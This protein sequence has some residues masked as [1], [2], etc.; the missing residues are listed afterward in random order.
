MKAFFRAFSVGLCVLM[1]CTGIS[2]FASTAVSENGHFNTD[3]DGKERYYVGD[4]YLKDGVYKIGDYEYVFASDGECLGAYDGYKNHGTLGLM[5]NERF[6]A[7]LAERTVHI[8]QSNNVGDENGVFN[9]GGTVNEVPKTVMDASAKLYPQLSGNYVMYSLSGATYSL[10]PKGGNAQNGNLAVFYGYPS[11]HTYCDS[12]GIYNTLGSEN[13]AIIDVEIK[14]EG[15]FAFSGKRAL[16][17]VTDRANESGESANISITLLQMDR[18]GMVYAKGV[19]DG[20]VALLNT[21]EFTRLSVAFHINENTFDV[22]LNGVLIRSG[23]ALYDETVEGNDAFRLEE[24]RICNA[25]NNDKAGY[26]ID[27]FSVYSGDKPVCLNAD[28]TLK[29]GYVQEGSYLRYY[30]NG[31][32]FT[33]KKK[34]SGTFFGKTLE[35]ESVTFSSENGGAMIGCKLKVTNGGITV[36]D[37]FAKNNTFVA[38]STAMTGKKQLGWSLTANGNSSFVENG[39]SIHL[40]YDTEASALGVEF[41]MLSGASV[42]LDGKENALR[43]YGKISKADLENLKSLGL[44]VEIHIVTAPTSTFEKAHGYIEY[45]HLLAASDGEEKPVDTVIKNGK[46]FKETDGYFYYSTVIGGISD[47]TKEYS[48]VTYLKITIENGSTVDVYGDYSEENNSRSVYDVAF[49]AYNDRS[50]EKISGKATKLVNYNGVRTYS[51]YSRSERKSLENIVNKVVS[52]VSEGTNAKASGDFYE[53]PYKISVEKGENGYTVKLT[54]Y[55]WSKNKP[56]A[57]TVNGESISLEACTLDKDSFSFGYEGDKVYL[58]DFEEITDSAY[59]G[60]KSV[61]ISSSTDSEQFSGVKALPTTIGGISVVSPDG[62]G[63]NA[64]LWEYTKY[65]IDLTATASLQ[66]YKKGEKYD[67]SGVKA[68]SFRVYVPNGSENSTFYIIADSATESNADAYYSYAVKLENSGW[69]NIF[70]NLSAASQNGTPAGWD[71]IDE[72][73][74]TSSGWSQSNSTSTRLLFYEIAAYDEKQSDR[75]YNTAGKISGSYNVALF[76]IGGYAGAVEGRIIPIN[77]L[78]RDV[79]V[80]KDTDGVI[81]LPV[82]VFAVNIDENA[83]Y[84]TGTETVSYIDDEQRYRFYDGTSYTVDG[85]K[86][87]LKYPAVAKNGGV[88]ISVYDAMDIYGY[89]DYY[90]NENRL[91]TLSNSGNILTSEADSDTAYS[92]VEDLIYVRPNG[93]TVYNDLMKTTGGQ[94]PY[95][96]LNS[97]RLSD[98]NYYK[99]NDATYASYVEAYMEKWGI[100]SSAF[101]V[102]PLYFNQYDG[103]R[104]STRTHAYNWALLYH[105]GNYNETEKKQLLDKVWSE[106]EAYSCYFHTEKDKYGWHPE[107]YLDVAGTALPMALAYDWLYDA[108][109]PEQ[110]SQIART[111]YEFVLKTTCALDEGGYSYELY[112]EGNWNGV[113]NAAVICSALAIV[114]DD[115]IISN[116]LQAD[117]LTVLETSIAAIEK[118]QERYVPDGGY[119]EG[120]NYWNYGT[121]NVVQFMAALESACGTTYGTYNSVGFD[122]AAYFGS[123]MGTGSY[124]WNYHDSGSSYL[125]QAFI[126]WFAK[127]NNDPNLNAVRRKDFEDGIATVS[128][129][130]IIYYDPHFISDSVE[131]GLDVYY[132]YDAIMTFRSSW[133]SGNSIFAGLH[134]G[135][136][137]AGHGDMDAG[138]FVITVDGVPMIVDLGADD[139]NCSG[140]SMMMYNNQRWSYYRKRAEGHNTLSVIGAGESWNGATGTPTK[141]VMPDMQR[142]GQVLYS[143]TKAYA[144][145][146]GTSSAYGIMDM[147]SALDFRAANGMGTDIKASG[148]YRGLYMTN[149]RST[150]VIQDEAEFT[151]SKDIWWFAHTESAEITL[152]NGGKGAV[153]YRNGIYLY[154]EIVVGPKH[155]GEAVFEIM[156]AESLD[157]SYTGD[158]IKGSI[159]TGVEYSRSNLKKLGIKCSDTVSYQLA[160]AFTVISDMSDVPTLG[161]TYVWKPMSEWTAE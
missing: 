62:I 39:Q 154:A 21:T 100:G 32:V 78:N 70:V 158:T 98:I 144:Y 36:S 143:R 96:L 25:F 117:V 90:E 75:S 14:L 53:A 109:T 129:Y 61:F 24:C 103:Q 89:S 31:C 73:Y 87:E 130:D 94:H 124:V 77:P 42:K 7:E 150:V 99:K 118:G 43:V 116:G 27:N 67:L 12:R 22:Y 125:N 68:L 38:E 112:S 30:N 123:Y 145:K 9:G 44:D 56:S 26:Y 6:K 105:I 79:T 83:V 63:D 120:P 81:Y 60:N 3:S 66:K 82:S 97:E 10:L 80:F 84:Y 76:A 136:N 141:D 108:W 127:M 137:K 72:M 28:Q 111:L 135:Y 121:T 37:G 35:E 107:H 155:E 88:F 29:N 134:G 1:L 48:A 19:N 153:I 104:L 140:Y 115:Y 85:V 161:T 138:N 91:V 113:C 15:N 41:G 126:V 45:E 59:N 58:G 55:D 92:C 64:L 50:S 49:A 71:S 132:S 51:P 17:S 152:V 18:Y 110:R 101:T 157:K 52:I 93:S 160:V 69:N 133:D 34:V 13:D 122:L 146:S 20:A 16:L 156:A 54:D 95:L 114:N 119:E 106:L 131:L 5:D 33:G 65:K 2:V 147:S 57:V 40:S 142:A 11:D 8:N 102:S 159:D 23:L 74:L 47:V 139:Y 4:E 148:A 46:W 151:S 86:K 149:N 128:Y